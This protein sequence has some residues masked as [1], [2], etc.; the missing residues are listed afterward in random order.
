MSDQSEVVPLVVNDS[1]LQRI[2]Y[3]GWR[4]FALT[5]LRPHAHYEVRISYPATMPSKF[6]LRLIGDA[7]KDLRRSLFN[8]EK[9]MFK[10]G[11][12]GEILGFS[13]PRGLS[14]TVCVEVEAEGVSF[15]SKAPN[16]VQFNIVLEELF[17]DIPYGAIKLGVVASLALVLAFVFAVPAVHRFASRPPQR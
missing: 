1:Q 11:A 13:L 5:A 10:T 6:S 14:Y 9:L 2:T 15:Q 3:G 4:L 12:L 17:Y 16:F 7:E 8:T